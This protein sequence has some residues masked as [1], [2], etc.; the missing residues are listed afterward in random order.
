VA[1]STHESKP[2]GKACILY[3][4][5]PEAREVVLKPL[6][7]E[8]NGK[9]P[10]IIKALRQ[11]KP[12]YEEVMGVFLKVNHTFVLYKKNDW[13]F[14]DVKKNVIL[15]IKKIKIIIESV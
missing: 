2:C 5:P 13:D 10:G 11:D 3:R 1:S 15:G 7:N 14:G 4:C 12:L 8:W 9:M 6:C